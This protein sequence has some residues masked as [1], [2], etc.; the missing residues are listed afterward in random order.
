MSN[1]PLFRVH[2][3]NEQ[4][5]EKARQL[6]TSFDDLLDQLERL[7]GPTGVNSREFSIVKTNLETASFYA[8]KAMASQ[9]ENQKPTP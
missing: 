2:L 7:V 5:V 1:S 4:G 6:A 8:K 3:L 9:P